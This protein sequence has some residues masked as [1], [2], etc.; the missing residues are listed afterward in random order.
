MTHRAALSMVQVRPKRRPEEWRQ[1]GNI[2]DQGASLIDWLDGAMSNFT[3]TA[4]EGNREVVC[5]A[6]QFVSDDELFLSLLHGETGVVAQIRNAGVL[7]Y[8]Q[9]IDDTHLV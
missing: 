1:L 8:Q 4:S 7:R 3:S 2:D 5:E 6:Q 9:A